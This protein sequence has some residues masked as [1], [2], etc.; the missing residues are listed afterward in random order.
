MTTAP[1]TYVVDTHALVWYLTDDMKLSEEAAAII[2]KSERG[3]PTVVIPTIVENL[4]SGDG[5]C[6]H[7]GRRGRR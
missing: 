4:R 3:D 2:E 5:D 1:N 6:K 7:E